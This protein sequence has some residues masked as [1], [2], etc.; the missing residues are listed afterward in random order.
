MAEV[1]KFYSGKE[2]TSKLLDM[3]EDDSDDDANPLG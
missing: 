1:K 2:A 3:L